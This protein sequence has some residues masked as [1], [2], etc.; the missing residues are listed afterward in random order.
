MDFEA[1]KA[2]LEERFEFVF[3]HHLHQK[4]ERILRALLLKKYI[5]SHRS[6][7]RLSNRN[8]H[9]HTHTHRCRYRYGHSKKAFVKRG[10]DVPQDMDISVQTG[11]RTDREQ[12]HYLLGEQVNQNADD[13][14]HPL[15]VPHL[16][17]VAAQSRQQWYKENRSKH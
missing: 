3:A 5:A 16:G 1:R 10:R 6:R 17:R 9:R 12:T 8:S 2:V 13:E 7:H 4:P 15:T 11:T 14:V